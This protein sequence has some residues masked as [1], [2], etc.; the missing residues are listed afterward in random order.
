MLRESSNPY[1]A[2]AAKQSQGRTGYTIRD[3]LEDGPS[4]QTDQLDSPLTESVVR[5]VFGINRSVG[6]LQNKLSAVSIRFNWGNYFRKIA[7]LHWSKP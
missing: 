3:G 5:K 6:T 7:R 2:T 4:S 1:L